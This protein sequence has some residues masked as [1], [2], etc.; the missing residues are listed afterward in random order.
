MFLSFESQDH[1]NFGNNFDRNLLNTA[2]YFLVSPGT[3]RNNLNFLN[4]CFIYI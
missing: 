1:S 4:Q 2:S 3:I